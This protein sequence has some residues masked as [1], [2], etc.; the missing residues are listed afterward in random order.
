MVMGQGR[1]FDPEKPWPTF[2]QRSNQI[3]LLLAALVFVQFLLNGLQ[4][5]LP[6][7][8]MLV[9]WIGT[10]ASVAILTMHIENF[11]LKQW[12]MK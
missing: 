5:V 6:G 7:V 4:N 8:V 3:A 12:R 9:L 2:V 1:S 11:I 10:G